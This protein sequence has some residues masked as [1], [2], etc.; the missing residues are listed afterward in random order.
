MSIT[1]IFLVIMA[2]SAFVAIIEIIFFF[3]HDEENQP[4]QR[5][6][7]PYDID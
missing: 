3:F 1:A 5:W 7:D 4:S 6:K 2:V